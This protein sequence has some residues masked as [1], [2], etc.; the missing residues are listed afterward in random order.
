MPIP[1][2]WPQ[3]TDAGASGVVYNL[4]IFPNHLK[5][6]QVVHAFGFGITTW[7]CWQAVSSRTRSDN[8]EAL[9]PTLGIMTLCAAAGMGF[10]ALNEIIEFIA[11]LTLPKTNVGGYENTGW[12]LVYNMIGSIIAAVAI[13]IGW[14]KTSPNPQAG[15]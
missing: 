5:Y 9:R 2:H 4:W 3:N 1:A 6:D 11:T 8:G 10:G 12:D 15:Q 14:R 13:S 7:L